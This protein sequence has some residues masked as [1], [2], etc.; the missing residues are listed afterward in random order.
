MTAWFLTF[1]WRHVKQHPITQTK[2]AFYPYFPRAVFIR[3][4]GGVEQAF[5]NPC[6]CL[7]QTPNMKAVH[8]SSVLLLALQQR[9]ERHETKQT[10]RTRSS[11]GPEVSSSSLLLIDDPPDAARP[12]LPPW[13]AEAAAHLPFEKKRRAPACLAP[14]PNSTSRAYWKKMYELFK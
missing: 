14:L 7:Q 8:R 1:C 4:G 2:S 5:Q 10:T 3:G 12:P 6:C 11:F 9:R 13:E